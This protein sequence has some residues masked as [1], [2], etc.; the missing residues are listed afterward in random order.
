MLGFVVALL[1]CLGG[2]AGLVVVIPGAI[3][4]WR[5]VPAY[6]NLSRAALPL[7]TVLYFG[8]VVLRLDLFNQR[9][10]LSYGLLALL[11]LAV[12]G[13][14]VYIYREPGA[15]QKRELAHTGV[16]RPEMPEIEIRQA[17]DADLPGAGLVFARVFHQSFDLDFGPD[18]ARNGRLLGELLKIKQPEVWVAALGES[19]Q[20]VGALWL[21][22]ADPQTPTVTAPVIRPILQKYMHRFYA[23]Y[24]AHLVMPNIMEVRGTPTSGYIQ[25]VGVDPDWQGYGIGR[26][27]VEQALKVTQAAGKHE[28]VLHTERS[29]R[30]ARRLYETSGFWNEGTF[31]LSPRIRYVKL[32]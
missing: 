18:R 4:A 32:F 22:L 30:R 26:R 13:I 11:S 5:V 14:V 2:L 3:R 24:F 9:P 23:A 1:M 27:L 31:P 15:S 19:G 16:S 25:W 17:T 28:L 7:L 21:D 8:S 29:N 10:W 20:V 12:L 6:Y